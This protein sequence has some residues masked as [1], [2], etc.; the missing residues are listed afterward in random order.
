V[1]D[2][3]W[4]GEPPRHE[5]RH[6]GIVSLSLHFVQAGMSS[7]GV[8]RHIAWRTSPMPVVSQSSLNA[9]LVAG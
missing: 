7:W 8:N 3:L 2:R 4:T 1:G 6:P 9:W 5:T